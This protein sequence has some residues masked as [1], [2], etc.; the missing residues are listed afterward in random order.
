MSFVYE[1]N[2]LKRDIVQS[3]GFQIE[4]TGLYVYNNC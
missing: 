3:R 2:R 1:F 4:T